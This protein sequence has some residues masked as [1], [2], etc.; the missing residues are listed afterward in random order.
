MNVHS[1]NSRKARAP[2][3]EPARANERTKRRRGRPRTGGRRE[4]V[5]AAALGMFAE[6]GFHG[7]AMPEIAA[8]AGVAT[9]TIYRH[10]ASKEALVNEL[11][12]M[13]KR[14]LA[15][16]LD[17][18]ATHG[19]MRER[20]HALWRGL[21]DFARDEPLAFAFLELHHHETYLDETSLQME[22]EILMPI[23]VALE[24]GKREGAIK[25]LPV[26]VLMV[27]VW[28]AFVA[29]CKNARRGYYHLTDEVC[30][31]VEHICW[32]AIAR[33]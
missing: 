23:V 4:D 22:R 6:R 1:H 16:H 19:A 31:Q 2:K 25:P 17:G 14:S 21:V 15:A 26:P 5:L 28:G 10:F 8:G 13:C 3:A 20:F 7:T 30:S 24:Q 32:D 18:A 12:Q 11:F 29:M 33:T 27:T 9:G